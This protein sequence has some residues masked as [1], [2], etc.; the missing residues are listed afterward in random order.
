[1][2]RKHTLITAALLATLSLS[3]CGKKKE[4][5]ATPPTPQS[6]SQKTPD[7]KIPAPGDS[8]DSTDQGDTNGNL[9]GGLPNPGTGSDNDYTPPSDDQDG[10][11]PTPIPN[12]GG[13]GSQG[14]GHS[15]RPGTRPGVPP[16][17]TPPPPIVDSK[18]A[19]TQREEV[20]DNYVPND[21]NNVTREGLSKRFTGGVAADGLLYTSSSTDELL[22]YL[23]ARNE[24][25]SGE[26][27]RANERAAASV[28]SAKMSV[29]SLS[30][31]AIVTLKVQEFNGVAT[32]NVA[33]SSEAGQANPLRLVRAGN[34][35]KTTGTRA[36][37]GT[38]KCVD[39]DGGC[40][41]VFV[42]LK[43]GTSP[44]SAII[45]VVF[46]TSTTDLWFSLPAVENQSSNREFLLLKEL[47]INTIQKN[48]KSENRLRSA[49][50][51]SW[52]VV[53]GRSGVTLTM[54]AYNGELL[55]FAGPLLAP[56]AGTGVN[57]R[58]ARLAAEQEDSLDLITVGSNK[59]NYQNYLGDARL[60]ANNG[61]GQVRIAL[62]MRKRVNYPQDQFAITF[63]RK[64]KPLVEL[65]DENLK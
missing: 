64:I 65:T 53:N 43:I 50:M 42:R 21:A 63:M 27:R 59:L 56:E 25:V 29:D 30:G 4:V 28:V 57:I 24:R 10:E 51:K 20:P 5:L 22:N 33:G 41:N 12:D 61:L 60:V 32:Y 35:E 31:D 19:P 1:M 3:A 58:L 6:D 7:A 9:G 52:E 45:N 39:F 13:N 49:T 62:K 46:R 26:T 55:A 38:W 40:E 17:A 18:P 11:E 36:L 48:R 15:S 34:G 8:G 23:R 16:R 44:D 47:A 14:D 2:L 54:K 37:E